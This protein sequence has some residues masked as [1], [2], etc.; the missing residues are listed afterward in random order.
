MKLGVFIEENIF[1][2][3]TQMYG[4]IFKQVQ[5]KKGV[6]PTFLKLPLNP[7]EDQISEEIKTYGFRF[8]F[9][10]L[11]T[12]DVEIVKKDSGIWYYPAVSLI[13]SQI[14]EHCN[15][16]NLELGPILTNFRDYCREINKQE[17]IENYKILTEKDKIIFFL[18]KAKSTKLWAIDIETTPYP[19]YHKDFELISISFSH[20]PGI[21]IAFP[22][23]HPEINFSKEEIQ[24]INDKLY[25][26]LSDPSIHLIGHNI[27]KFDKIGIEKYLGKRI[28]QSYEETLRRFDDTMIMKYALNENHKGR[29]SLKICL[30][31]YL[32][33][34]DWGIDTSNLKETPIKQI[35]EYNALDTDATIS[36]YYEFLDKIKQESI[37]LGI[38]VYES[39]KTVLLPNACNAAILDDNGLAANTEYAEKYYKR[40]QRR[41]KR[42]KK[43][44]CNNPYV[45][46]H[47]RFLRNEKLKSRK[48]IPAKGTKMYE[49]MMETLSKI[50]FN[51][52][53][54]KDTE[55]IL[56]DKMGLEYPEEFGRTPTGKRKMGMDVFKHLE[57]KQGS[58]FCRALY[59]IHTMEADMSNY[60]VPVLE[61]IKLTKSGVTHPSF[62]A[63]G[64]DTGRFSCRNADANSS[65]VGVGQNLQ[66]IKKSKEIK[67]LYKSRF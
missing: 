47:I 45:K 46:D 9:V 20:K 24:E 12:N 32:E 57:E 14:E 25:E 23:N 11:S 21:S 28:S 66:K 40:I 16:F 56:F 36:L 29:Y 64:T 61:S 67:A 59:F 34:P 7:S 51:P 44:V 62:N 39:Y 60:V 30:Q 22:V 10:I 58:R 54:K 3:E 8:N 49:K 18:E 1:N 33:W 41:L 31:D 6:I 43:Y 52:T 50:K 19:P 48:R 37:I 13:N 55:Y 5:M 35:L 63:V 15:F 17:K 38:D 42:Y 53:G 26:F 4:N 27:L 65:G 2:I